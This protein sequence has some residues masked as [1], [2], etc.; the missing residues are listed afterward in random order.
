MTRRDTT[1][2]KTPSLSELPPIRS[3]SWPRLW[4]DFKLA[5]PDW[6]GRLP[7]DEA[8]YSLS[9]KI[10]D[11][12][13]KPRG[14]HR[15]LR[16]VLA[17]A[18]AQAEQNFDHLC[19][20][21][22]P[23]AIGVYQNA[24]LIFPL[25]SENWA[26][27]GADHSSLTSKRFGKNTTDSERKFLDDV[28][29]THEQQVA[30]AGALTFHE[31]Y[32]KE[33]ADLRAKWS[34]LSTP[35][36]CLGPWMPA[37]LARKAKLSQECVNYYMA[38]DFFRARWDIAMLVSWD[39]PWPAGQIDHM[40]ATEVVAALG[41]DFLVTYCP[42]YLKTP[43]Q[44][45]NHKLQ[46]TNALAKVLPGRPIP[47]SFR[48]STGQGSGSH[49][50]KTAFHMWLIELTVLRRY[51]PHAGLTSC[52]LRGMAKFFDRSTGQLKKLRRIYADFL[53][54]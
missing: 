5:H 22:N 38:Y 51:G 50:Y 2:P 33:L 39:I 26:I 12:M 6:V 20:T 9:P 37:R 54:S 35:K 41:P 48:A 32:R 18:D 52:L 25:L 28:D 8:A 21:F 14:R 44:T 3:S 42:A 24:P 46:L 43:T 27:E 23:H 30:Y 16:P 49:E 10:V 34:A 40:T 45:V 53:P 11:E 36:P 17:N 29:Y 4:A 13:V 31:P 47:P 7:S 19:R 15:K 1:N